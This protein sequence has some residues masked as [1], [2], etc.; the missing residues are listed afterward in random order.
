MKRILTLIT[1]VLTLGLS[2][3]SISDILEKAGLGDNDDGSTPLTPI[4][5]KADY[6]IGVGWIPFEKTYTGTAWENINLRKGP[7]IDAPIA[8]TVDKGTILKLYGVSVACSL[9]MSDDE[10][11]KYVLENDPKD[12]YE[13]G[14]FEAYTR[15][16]MAWYRV[17]YGG[18]FVW[19]H[20]AYIGTDAPDGIPEYAIPMVGSYSE[21]LYFDKNGKLERVV[22]ESLSD[23]KFTDKVV[24][25]AVTAGGIERW[26]FLRVQYFGAEPS[27]PA[28]DLRRCT[29]RAFDLHRGKELGKD[30]PR[31]FAVLSDAGVVIADFEE[32]A[33]G[34][35]V[36]DT[37][38]ARVI[39]ADGAGNIKKECD[40]FALPLYLTG[41]GADGVWAADPYAKRVIRLNG[42]AQPV[43][44]IDDGIVTDAIAFNAVTH[45]LWL[46][47]YTP[48]E[49][50]IFWGDGSLSVYD[51]N[52]GLAGLNDRYE[53]VIYDD[54][55]PSDYTLEQALKAVFELKPDGSVTLYSYISGEGT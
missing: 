8:T 9:V 44:I 15:R 43:G 5:L 39:L 14:L 47:G 31:W 22:V 6:A 24:P 45:Q 23:V 12:E 34:V 52:G 4:D 54:G 50:S 18:E 42:D 11:V 35:W 27:E 29:P 53:N 38:G 13:R 49:Y 55:Q 37:A 21:A 20:A 36:A 46:Y 10:W 16:K 48:G 32:T 40:R 33:A 26:E 25:F 3:C 19:A 17:K 28:Y 51:E 30:V 2:A 1:V 41:D 7:S